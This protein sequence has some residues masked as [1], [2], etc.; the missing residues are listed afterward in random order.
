MTRN[1]VGLA[2]VP[3]ENRIRENNEKAPRDYS[4]E[5]KRKSEP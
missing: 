2:V 4:G 3:Q 1:G 5:D